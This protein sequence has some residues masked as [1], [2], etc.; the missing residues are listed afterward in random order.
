[1]CQV[2]QVEMGWASK[3]TSPA[4][5]MGL[6]RPEMGLEAVL[7]SGRGIGEKPSEKWGRKGV[8]EEIRLFRLNHYEDG[9]AVTGIDFHFE[10]VCLD[11]IDRRRTDYCQHGQ[12]VFKLRSIR[13]C[14]GPGGDL[15]ELQRCSK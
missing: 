11:S 1:M 8:S 3:H 14:F 15:V 5:G 6:D 12:G 13:N 9:V 2:T 4:A 10:G 7:T